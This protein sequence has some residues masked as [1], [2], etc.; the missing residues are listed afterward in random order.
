[1]RTCE[2]IACSHLRDLWPLSSTWQWLNR[3]CGG[4]NRFGREVDAFRAF[5]L[6]SSRLHRQTLTSQP[7]EGCVSGSRGP[8]RFVYEIPKTSILVAPREKKRQRPKTKLFTLL[9]YP[10]D[11][12]LRAEML[13]HKIF[14]YLIDCR[15]NVSRHSWPPE[16]PTF[17]FLSSNFSYSQQIRFP[18]VWHSI[19]LSV[20][21]LLIRSHEMFN[22]PRGLVTVGRAQKKESSKGRSLGSILNRCPKPPPKPPP[23]VSVV[24]V[25]HSPLK[26]TKNIN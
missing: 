3:I 18:L 26:I 15:S 5:C 10:R 20:S 8:E 16:D 22:N 21:F 17:I 23:L 12:A 2:R 7:H 14:I 19:H 24:L 6:P 11:S 25:K 4:G 9:L 13:L 1:M